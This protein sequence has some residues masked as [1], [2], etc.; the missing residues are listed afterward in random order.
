M[1]FRL[2]YHLGTLDQTHYLP[3]PPLPNEKHPHPPTWGFR[4]KQPQTLVNR[5]GYTQGIP[6]PWLGEGP[7]VGADT[8][9]EDFSTPVALHEGAGAHHGHGHIVGPKAGPKHSEDPQE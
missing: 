8:Y 4:N 3:K 9:N 6:R 7:S 1:A 2:D 5:K